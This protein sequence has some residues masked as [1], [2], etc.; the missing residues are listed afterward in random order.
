ME[1]TRDISELLVRP[2][3]PGD[4]AQVSE[5]IGQLGYA[6]SPQQIV[7]WIVSA[8]SGNEHAA[9]VA[10]LRNEV[11]GWIVVSIERRLQYPPFGYVGGLVVKDRL[12][13]QGIGRRLCRHAE[14]WSWSRSVELV[15]VT[16]RSTRTD[17]H[18]FYVHGGYDTVKTSLVFEKR[19]P[20]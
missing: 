3:E 7:E 6:R 12:R 14:D 9:F 2:I 17:A 16:S 5:L 18:R 11:V 15:R 20:G 19:R 4:A 13:G 8:G 1:S 10:C